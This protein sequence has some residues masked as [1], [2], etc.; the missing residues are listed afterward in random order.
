M[1]VCQCGVLIHIQCDWYSVVVV[2]EYLIRTPVRK[3]RHEHPQNER[4]VKML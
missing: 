4:V 1:L 2:R 3:K